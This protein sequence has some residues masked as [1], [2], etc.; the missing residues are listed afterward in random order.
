MRDAFMLS[1]DVAH[2]THPNYSEKSDPTNQIVMGRGV[3]LKS[4][5]SQ[6]YVSDS[7]AS[8]VIMALS[9]NQEIKIQRQ[10]NRSGMAGGQTLG[11]SEL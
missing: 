2:A 7:E 5:A 4:S 1:L 9:R 3:A 8:A 6:R 10:V 11:Q